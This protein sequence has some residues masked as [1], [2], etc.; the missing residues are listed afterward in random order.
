MLPSATAP[1]VDLERFIEHHLHATLDQYAD[2]PSEV[3]GVTE[4]RRRMPPKILVNRDLTGSALDGDDSA[5]G[6]LGRWRATLAHE[7]GHI[8]LHRSLFEVDE[9]QGELFGVEATAQDELM[10]CL[11]RDVGYGRGGA[12]WREVQANKAMAAMLM[13][14][15]TFKKVVRSELA[16]M[17]ITRARLRDGTPAHRVLIKRLSRRLEVSRQAASIRLETTGLVTPVDTPLL[18]DE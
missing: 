8:L 9:N 6:V 2:L 10:Q 7:V 4:F 12:D 1:V 16:D 11:K 3:L 14:G 5:P 13:P 15:R 17:G 18:A